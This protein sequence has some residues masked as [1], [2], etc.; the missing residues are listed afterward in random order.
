MHAFVKRQTCPMSPKPSCKKCP[1]NCYA[2][3]Y[4]ARIREVMKVSGRRLVLRG[5]LDYLLHLYA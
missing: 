5:R 3:A 4:R 2:S 1:Q